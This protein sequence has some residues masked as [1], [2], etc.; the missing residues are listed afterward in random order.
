MQLGGGG[1]QT[2]GYNM[3]NMLDKMF[4]NVLRRGVGEGV[5]FWSIWRYIIYEQS[6]TTSVV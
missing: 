2:L 1:G 3:V 6:R 4:F 5:M